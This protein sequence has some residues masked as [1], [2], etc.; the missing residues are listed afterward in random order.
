MAK[1]KLSKSAGRF[2]PRYGV[3]VRRRIAAIEEIQ[4]KKQQCIFCNGL[5]KRLSKGIWICKKCGKKFAGHA[6]YL[7]TK[8]KLESNKGEIKTKP[9]KKETSSLESADKNKPKKKRVQ[10]NK[11]NKQ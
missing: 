7:A 2:G 10:K 9:L 3:S 4:K 1:L 5:A 11:E 6:Y 8:E